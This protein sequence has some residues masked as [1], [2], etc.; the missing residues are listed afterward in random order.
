MDSALIIARVVHVLSGVFWAGT[1]VFVAAFLF[2]AVRDAGP[3]G[4]KVIA[5]LAKHHFLTVMPIIAI[6]SMLSGFW[7]YWRVSLGFGPAF[8]RSGPG[9]AY[10]IG[11]AAAVLAFI[12]GVTMVR[13]GMKKA[14]ELSQSAANAGASE[15]EAMLA[16]AQAL[17]VRG[18][19][20]GNWVAMLLGI[21][22]LAMA[23]G[24]YV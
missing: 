6:L 11:G 15:R 7:L 13:P 5:G 24:R 12:I 14:L 17:R 1:M 8:M 16:K 21:A 20:L 19:K 22:A 23:V 2:P 3:E 10:G 18:G 9:M 4:G